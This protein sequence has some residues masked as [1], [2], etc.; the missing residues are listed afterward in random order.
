[1]PI[2][3]R[4]L[5]AEFLGAYVLLGFG[6]F[7]IFSANVAP[8]ASG[9]QGTPLLLIAFGFGLALL[10]GL[11]A[12]G[13]IS[14]G[15]YNPAV[16][17]GALIDGRI[18]VSSFIGYVV[19]QV[20]G[21]TFAG[22][23][24]A[25]AFNQAFVASTAT[26]PN[27]AL[28]VTDLEAFLLEALFTAFFVAVILKVTASDTFGASA[29]IAISLTLVAIHIALVPLTGASVNP[30]RTLGSAIIGNEWTSIWVYM[31]APFIGAF[32]GWGLFKLVTFDKDDD[33]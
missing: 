27:A 14:G 13:E 32:V 30:A 20:A 26:V 8:G 17:L 31:T 25:Y 29:L 16:S 33:A 22:A 23:T 3:T 4:R 18:D 9:P 10:V 21:A 5:L 11:Y 24:L 7:A 1:M 19:A 6:G 2:F 28:G 15:H 12:F